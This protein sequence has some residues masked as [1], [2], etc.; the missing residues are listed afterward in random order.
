MAIVKAEQIQSFAELVVK[1]YQAAT[2]LKSNIYVC[3]P[4]HGAEALKVAVDNG[5][6]LVEL[7]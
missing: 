5:V 1:C 7:S 6:E 4:A 3:A 2:S